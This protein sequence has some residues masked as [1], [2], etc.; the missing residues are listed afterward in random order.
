MIKFGQLKMFS[1][2]VRTPVTSIPHGIS[3]GL[4]YGTVTFSDSRSYLSNELLCMRLSTTVLLSQAFPFE[5]TYNKKVKNL[6]SGKLINV[7]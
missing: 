4:K 5:Q 1:W 7:F 6:I 3:T 2:G